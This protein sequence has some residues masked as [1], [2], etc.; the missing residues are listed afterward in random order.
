MHTY[1]AT[2]LEHSLAMAFGD[3]F[4]LDSVKS[5]ALADFCV[6]CG[7]SRSFFARELENLC[8]IAI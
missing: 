5:F 7:V 8:S 6:R 1:D 4:E 3:V 2:K